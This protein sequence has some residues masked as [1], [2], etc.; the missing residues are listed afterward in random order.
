MRALL[1]LT[2]ATGISLSLRAFFEARTVSDLASAL[3]AEIEQVMR[4]CAQAD[5]AEPAVAVTGAQTGSGET[6]RDHT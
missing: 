2:E 4:T 6:T 1:R 3:E 5:S